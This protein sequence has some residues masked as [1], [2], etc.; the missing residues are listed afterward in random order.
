MV[1]IIFGQTFTVMQT[2]VC[3]MLTTLSITTT[4]SQTGVK[5]DVFVQD[6]SD[7]FTTKMTA[8]GDTNPLLMK[9]VINGDE[10]TAT[11]N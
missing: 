8:T 9:V 10:W 7:A 5:E 11:A 3:G 4:I 6:S 2:L 1:H